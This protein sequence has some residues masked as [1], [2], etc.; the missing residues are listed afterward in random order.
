[1][2]NH[3]QFK[4]H[5]QRTRKTMRLSQAHHALDEKCLGALSFSLLLLLRSKNSQS[6]QCGVLWACRSVIF[7]AWHRRTTK[8]TSGFIL[9]HCKETWPRLLKKDVAVQDGRRC[10][11]RRCGEINGWPRLVSGYDWCHYQPHCFPNDF[12]K[13]LIECVWNPTT[14]NPLRALFCVVSE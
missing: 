6:K 1:M 9:S 3:S 10:D 8:Y 5:T 2:Q 7:S 13:S 14:K 11:Q 4:T 12:L